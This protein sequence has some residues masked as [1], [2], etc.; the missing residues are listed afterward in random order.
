MSPA[1]HVPGDQHGTP[2]R[3]DADASAVSAPGSAAHQPL[4]ELRA[5]TKTFGDVVADREVDLSVAGGEIHA[6]L[7]ENGAGKT[8]LMR[9]LAGLIRA[10]SG[11]IR[12]AGTPVHITSP[13]DAIRLGIGMMH[14]H[15]M[16]VSTLTVEENFELARPDPPAALGLGDTR[17]RVTALTERYGVDVRPDQRVETLTVGQRQ[18]VNLLRILDG[19][20]IR[21]LILDEPTASLTQAEREDVFRTL[22]DLRAQGVA[23]ILIVHKLGEVFD[24]CDR[25][26]VMRAGRVVATLSVA[27]TSKEQLASLMVGHAVDARLAGPPTAPGEVILEVSG[28]R[29][30]GAERDLSDVTFEVRRGEIVGIAGVDGNGQRELGE[31]LAGVRRPSAGAVRL[32]GDDVTGRHPTALT[33]MGVARIPEDRQEHGLAL[34]LR[35]WE[36]LQLGRSASRHLVRRGVVDNA[37]AR[38]IAAELAS[39]FDVRTA[40]LESPAGVLSGGN[41]QKVVLARE[42]GDDADLVLAMNPTRGLDIAATQFVY[43]QLVAVRTRGGGVLLVSFDLDELLALCDRVLVMSGGRIIGEVAA[44]GADR[45]LVG[46][47]MGGEAQHIPAEIPL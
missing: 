21:L 2:A 46:M 17:K 1:P 19:R 40:D 43:E 33:S 38:R 6:L 27:E 3:T 45:T 42:L 24:V 36:N 13:A 14:Q 47:M 9:V 26:T 32:R 37:R 7:G 39:R 30:A 23:V 5:I 12:W 16:L 22:R 25:A 29:T 15:D 35:I 4:V 41:Q 44:A 18:W 28:L 20:E 11:E 31:C 34:G 8:T 10:D